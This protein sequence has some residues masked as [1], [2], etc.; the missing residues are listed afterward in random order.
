MVLAS[1]YHQHTLYFYIP[2]FQ[3]LVR[4]GGDIP[5]VSPEVI[6][7]LLFLR[8]LWGMDAPMEQSMNIRFL[9]GVWSCICYYPAP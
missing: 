9:F 7:I 3:G 1:L 8:S 6:N 2:P 5:P 4:E